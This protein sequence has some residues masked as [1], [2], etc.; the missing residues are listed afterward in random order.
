MAKKLKQQIADIREDAKE[1]V[2]EELRGENLTPERKK[3]ILGEYKQI[4]I[5]LKEIEFRNRKKEAYKHTFKGLSEFKQLN[6]KTVYSDALSGRAEQD[7][8]AI[9]LEMAWAQV[10]SRFKVAYEEMASYLRPGIGKEL[11]DRCKIERGLARDLTGIVNVI[12]FLEI[13]DYTRATAAFIYFGLEN[14]MNDI[15]RYFNVNLGSMFKDTIKQIYANAKETGITQEQLKQTASSNMSYANAMTTNMKASVENVTEYGGIYN[16]KSSLGSKADKVQ[17]GKGFADFLK[18]ESGKAVSGACEFAFEAE[19]A[20]SAKL[21]EFDTPENGNFAKRLTAKN[22]LNN[23]VMELLNGESK[24]LEEDIAEL[25]KSL[26]IA[27]EQGNQAEVQKITQQLEDRTLQHKILL[28]FIAKCVGRP[29]HEKIQICDLLKK[30]LE[31]EKRKAS[32]LG[33]P[34]SEAE[35]GKLDKSLEEISGELGGILAGA[36]KTETKF[37]A[38]EIDVA[39]QEMAAIERRI[40]KGESTPADQNKYIELYSSTSRARTGEE[41]EKAR[42]A[43]VGRYTLTSV[44]NTYMH[45]ANVYYDESSSELCKYL[46]SG[47]EEINGY[48]FDLRL[49]RKPIKERAKEMIA[50]VERGEY[51]PAEAA[52]SEYFDAQVNSEHIQTMQNERSIDYLLSQIDN[53]NEDSRANAVCAVLN[54]I[55]DRLTKFKHNVR[56]DE[57]AILENAFNKVK[58]IASTIN[59]GPLNLKEI[60]GLLEK[61]RESFNT[62][63]I[64]YKITQKKFADIESGRAFEDYAKYLQDFYGSIK[65]LPKAFEVNYSIEDLERLQSQFDTCEQIIQERGIKIDDQLNSARTQARDK[66]KILLHRSRLNPAMDMS[67][68]LKLKTREERVDKIRESVKV[69]YD[70]IKSGAINV[71]DNRHIREWLSTY[72]KL[73]VL[74]WDN[75]NGDTL[76][77][78]NAMLVEISEWSCETDKHKFNVEITKLDNVMSE[79]IGMIE[80]DGITTETIVKLEECKQLYQSLKVEKKLH[81]KLVKELDEKYSK[82]EPYIKE[83]E[84]NLLKQQAIKLRDNFKQLLADKDFSSLPSIIQEYE[85]LKQKGALVIDKEVFDEIDTILESVHKAREQKIEPEK[86]STEASRKGDSPTSADQ[87]AIDIK[88]KIEHILTALKKGQTEFNVAEFQEL[89]SSLETLQNSDEGKT[90][91]QRIFEDAH[92]IIEEIKQWQKK[93]TPQNAEAQ[94]SGGF[95]VGGEVDSERAMAEYKRSPIPN[96]QGSKSSKA[97]KKDAT[98]QEI[99]EDLEQGSLKPH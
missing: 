27:R 14:R 2:R 36:A 12:K 53:P 97:S 76:T 5:K 61:K 25:S 34:G 39:K 80:K 63:D 35:I 57:L 9:S 69:I 47:C 56:E 16:N 4:N 22:T 15:E 66:L 42:T 94:K 65:D 41:I 64:K 20:Y 71:H 13:K 79:T 17:L 62:R 11:L 3:K 96:R 89:V 90:V 95:T 21:K 51:S 86:G 1:E 77:D 6:S 73:T 68:V 55:K 48:S 84:N 45:G 37:E 19:S 85:K 58:G 24:R 83:H 30:R 78:I 87:K 81:P 88:I 49:S 40:K 43:E 59:L 60:E 67:E 91:N 8:D 54:H 18:S 23:V 70:G 32:I 7:K 44:T 98:E 31:L 38:G 93:L 82:L 75:E 33:T 72:R 50:A 46:A 10:D 26:I 28:K 92:K 99:E 52:A 29:D 74:N